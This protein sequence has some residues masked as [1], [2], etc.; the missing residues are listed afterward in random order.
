MVC[1]ALLKSPPI[2][3]WLTTI[4]VL[5][6][7]LITTFVHSFLLFLLDLRLRI[8]GR[9]CISVLYWCISSSIRSKAVYLLSIITLFDEKCLMKAYKCP[10]KTFFRFKEIECDY[11][12]I[13]Y[14]HTALRI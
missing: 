12:G 10:L 1:N 5:V 14:I 8:F 2:R 3:V 11:D 13:T 6:S 4:S 9:V 7:V